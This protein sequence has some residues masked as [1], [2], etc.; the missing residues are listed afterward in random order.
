MSMSGHLQHNNIDVETVHHKNGGSVATVVEG[1]LHGGEGS[2]TEGGNNGGKDQ[3]EGEE[4]NGGGCTM[5]VHHERNYKRF[6]CT[7]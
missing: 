2:V 4:G 6:T 1:G 5:A 3:L 7:V